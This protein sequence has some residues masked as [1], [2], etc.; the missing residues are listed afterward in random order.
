VSADEHQFLGAHEALHW[1]CCNCNKKLGGIFGIVD[2]LASK[3]TNIVESLD[4][5]TE[6]K[7]CE[8]VSELKSEVAA[9]NLELSNLKELL[10]TKETN[11]SSQTAALSLEV[12][13]LK[14]A[15]GKK[16]ETNETE[17]KTMWADVVKQQVN[18]ELSTVQS[19]ITKI[20]TD[21]QDVRKQTE[22]EKIKRLDRTILLYTECLK[23]L[24]EKKELRRINNFALV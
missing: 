8:T 4:K 21:I 6:A 22:E 23:K 19:N 14:E 11:E 16:P 24:T 10:K 13:A 17:L 12:S 3:Q 15:I 5:L 1:Y 18:S 2:S 20:Q 7:L 9:L